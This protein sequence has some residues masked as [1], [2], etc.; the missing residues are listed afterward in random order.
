M[1]RKSYDV[2]L[3]G[4]SLNFQILDFPLVQLKTAPFM[5]KVTNLF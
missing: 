3:F 4:V 1:M 5:A 2:S